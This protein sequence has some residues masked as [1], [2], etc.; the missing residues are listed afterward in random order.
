MNTTKTSFWMGLVALLLTISVASSGCDYV[1]N[2]VEGDG[3]VVKE[4]R[5]VKAFDR[6]QVSGAFEVF[7]T[8]GNEEKL[9]IEADENLLELIETEVVNGKLKIYTSK[10]IRNARE[11]KAHITLKEL[12]GLDLSG[13]VELM[14]E[15]RIKTDELKIDGSGAIEMEMSIEADEIRGDFSGASEVEFSGYAKAFSFD[16]SGAAEL[17]AK[18][19]EVEI[20]RLNVSGAAEAKVYATKELHVDASGASSVRYKG[21]PEVYKSSSGASSVKAY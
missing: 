4:E 14:T 20:L 1:I 21:E 8:Q 6:V 18:E 7:L 13:A 5:E 17:D 12:H 19:L 2:G 3:N 9:V 10:S 11:M 15:N 16:A